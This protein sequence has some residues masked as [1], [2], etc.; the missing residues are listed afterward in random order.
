MSESPSSSFRINEWSGVLL[1]RQE[2]RASEA[3]SLD[4]HSCIQTLIDNVGCQIKSRHKSK[5]KLRW[6][7]TIRVLMVPEA[8]FLACCEVNQ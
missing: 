6:L 4:Q 3:R 5:K 7:S 8:Q 1:K 2:G